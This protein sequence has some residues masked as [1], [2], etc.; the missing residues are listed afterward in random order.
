[1]FVLMN[2]IAW[3]H[4]W[5]FT[6]FSDT[7]DARTSH[8]MT[9]VQKLKVVFTGVNNP[10]PALKVKPSGPYQIIRIQS[11]VLLEGWLM[12][13]NN[14]KGTVIIFHGYGGEKSSMLDKADVFL[15]LGYHVLLVDFMGSGGSAGNTTTIGYK[16]SLE[17]RD[18]FNH[19][20]NIGHRNL[21]LFGTSMGS[22]A[23]MKAIREYQLKP[24]S[25]II[26]CPFGSLYETVSARFHKQNIPVFPMAG[27]LVF[28]GGV[29]NGFNGFKHI[30]RNWAAA[31]DCPVLLMYGEKDDRVSRK[32]IDDI[33]QSLA[34]KKYLKTYTLAGHE[35]YLLK[36]RIEWTR[37]VKEFLFM[38]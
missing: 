15:N 17:V 4:A 28:W 9:T 12:H 29:Q 21:I 25:I 11:N 2:G 10:R 32:E 18:V 38:P 5:K 13:S 23:I 20:Q 35:N 31:I 3:M 8:D 36:H 14:A 16:E 26:E 6:H 19:M 1:M 7:L 27:L 33:F 22:V 30:P 37:D 24:T 34:G